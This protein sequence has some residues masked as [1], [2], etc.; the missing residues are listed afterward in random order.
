M[1]RCAAQWAR[2]TPAQ[3]WQ[4]RGGS[5]ARARQAGD[6]VSVLQWGCLGVVPQSGACAAARQDEQVGWYA[7]SIG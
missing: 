2:T 1:A 6:A 7:S 4:A 3:A 5:V